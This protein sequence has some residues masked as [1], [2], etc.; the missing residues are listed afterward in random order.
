MSKEKRG[1]QSGEKL[2]MDPQWNK[3]NRKFAYVQ[4]TISEEK[5]DYVSNIFIGDLIHGIMPF[6]DGENQTVSPRWSPDGDKLVFVSDRTKL[7]QI[8]VK[9]VNRGEAKQ[10]THCESGV[11]NPVWSPCGEMLVFSTIGTNPKVA[12]ELVLLN[13][14]TNELTPLVRECRNYHSVVW[15]PD[16]SFIAFSACAFSQP[17]TVVDVFILELETKE[18]RKLTN[19]NGFFTSTTWSP[20]GEKLGFVGYEKDNKGVPISRV[21]IY[22]FQYTQLTCLTSEFDI[23]VGNEIEGDFHWA[24]VNPGLLWTEDSEGFYFLVTDQGSNGIYYGSLDGAMY[25]IVLEQEHIYGMTVITDIHEA[26]AC[27]SKQTERVELYHLDFKTQE[28]TKLQT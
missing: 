6:T 25:P 18:I 13:V 1:F 8:Y 22:H 19:S 9:D 2:V 5:N 15:S 12:E 26:I 14:K 3:R 17:T 24:T 10:L 27:I 4:T 16:G 20:D 11:R 7:P 21:W 28:R 23:S